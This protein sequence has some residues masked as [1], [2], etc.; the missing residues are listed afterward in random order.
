MIGIGL[1]WGPSFPHTLLCDF[2]FL[3]TGYDH[4]DV[5][6]MVSCYQGMVARHCLWFAIREYG[7][8]SGSK[9]KIGA[10]LYYKL[11]CES[12]E[13]LGCYNLGQM[14]LT[15]DGVPQDTSKAKIFFQAACK[16]GYRQG[17][18]KAHE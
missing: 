1:Y 4:R 13:E 15:G 3:E 14:Y 6:C 9:E 16:F 18:V 2:D 5:N 8:E 11:A 17:C 12:R 7:R 10:S